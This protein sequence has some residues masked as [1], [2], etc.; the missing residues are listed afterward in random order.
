MLETL[1]PAA[2]VRLLDTELASA[3]WALVDHAA[4]LM[5]EALHRGLVPR[6]GI[7]QTGEPVDGLGVALSSYDDYD[8][9]EA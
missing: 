4:N 3:R 1:S 6:S 8:P 9:T 2:R 5:H 7:S